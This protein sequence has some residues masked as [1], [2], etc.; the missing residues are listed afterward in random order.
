MWE[1]PITAKH[2]DTL[3]SFGYQEVPC[4]SKILVCGDKGME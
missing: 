3:K 2:V 4:V 1:H